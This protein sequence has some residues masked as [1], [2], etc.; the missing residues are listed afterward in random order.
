LTKEEFLSDFRKESKLHPCITLVLYFGERWDGATSL[1]ELLDFS[2]IPTKLRRFVNDYPMYL[3]NV[4]DLQD[5]SVFQTDLRLVFDCIRH[6]EDKERFYQ[7]VLGNEEYQWL[8]EDAYDVIARYTK[9]LGDREVAVENKAEGGK[10]NMCK[11]MQELMADERA[12][13]KAEGRC[14]MIIELLGELG[15]LSE[16]LVHC[17]RQ[18][19]DMQVLS[20]WNRLAA[21]VE[22][23]REFELAM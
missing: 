18:E 2:E 16:E 8:D 13:G 7:N 5:T 3:V 14:D 19:K 11:A 6:A 10:V 9:V 20:R 4:R 15:S 12:E 17:I 23:A 22:T 21:R 1:Y